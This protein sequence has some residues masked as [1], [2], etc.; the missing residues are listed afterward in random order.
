MHSL[1]RNFISGMIRFFRV[2]EGF[3]KIN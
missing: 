2:E 3:E 1:I